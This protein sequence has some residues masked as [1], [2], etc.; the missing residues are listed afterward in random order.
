MRTPIQIKTFFPA[1]I[2]I[3]TILL[4]DISAR[5]QIVQT[6]SQSGANTLGWNAAIWGSPGAAPTSGN[7]YLTPSGFFVRTPNT[8][9]PGAFP[10][11]SLTISNA[12][13]YL[14]HDNGVATVNVIL[15][16]PTSQTGGDIIDYHGGPG[17][18]NV[19]LAG[20]LQVN[21]NSEIESDQT[22]SANE[23]IW[24]ECPLSGNGSL[25]VNM[26]DS[27]HGVLLFG[28]NSAYSGNWTNITGII[29]VMSGSSNALGSGSVTLNFS[30]ST[31]LIFNSTNNMAISNSIGGLGNVIQM[32][33]NTV[34]L[35]GTNTFA[36]F[37][38]ITNGGTLQ[39]GA[40]ATLTNSSLISLSGGTL[41]ASLIGGLTLGA[42]QSMNCNGALIGDLTVPGT[43]TLTFNFTAT[44]N[45]VLN[46][47]G[48]LTLNG[49]PTVAITASGFITPRTYRLINYNGTIQGGGSFNL[50]PPGGSTEVFQLD[51][52]TP[53]QVN[54]IVS[55]AVYNLTWVGDGVNNNW[56]L[57]ST[58]WFGATNVYADGDN[59]TFDDSGSA[60]PAIN[61][62]QTIHPGSVTINNDTNYYTFSG[63]GIVMTGSFAKT[64]TNEAD[65][66]SAANNIT[67]PLT[68]ES[69]I[70]S[71]GNGGITT[72]LGTPVSITNNGILQVNL[73]SGGLPLN[74]PI[75]GSGSLNITGGGASVTIGATN[76]YTG[77]TTIGDGCQLNISTS[78]ALGNSASVATVLANGRLGVN[79]LV[80]IMSVPQPLV[81]SGTGISTAPGAIYVNTSGNNVTWAG[82]VTVAA[83]AQF[84]TVNVSVH[85][86]FS[87]TVLGTNVALECTSGNTAGDSSTVMTFENTVS[88]GSSGSLTADGLAV[89]V[90]AGGTNVWGGGTTINNSGTLLV[91]GTLNGGPLADNNP[92]TLGG[93]GVILDPVTVDGTLAPGNLAI[94]TLTVSNTVTFNSD[95][96]AEFEINRTNAQ[97]ASL[98][99]AATVNCAGT[100]TVNN[101]G[102]TNLQAG[103]SFTLFSGAL[104]GSFSTT[105]LPALP[106]TN[107]FWDTSLLGSQGII[108]VNSSAVPQPTITSISVSGTTLTITATN[109]VVGGQ[110]V[111]L[112]STNLLLPVS[113]WTPIL[114][115]NFDNSGD[116]NLSTNVVNPGVPQEFY[117]LSP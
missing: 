14:K 102:P 101:I 8:T 62:V 10:G 32:N 25:N 71:F 92:A 113:Q 97:K 94:G 69:G 4:V 39:I 82:P 112:G 48:A 26:L 93:S 100:L 59:V 96:T 91:N 1:A 105:N 22:G 46:V 79:S 103:D 81:V 88:L 11:S 78:S 67:G 87:N 115:N 5:A 12:T 3:G 36:G 24:L 42:T 9:T 51:T 52:S 74:S 30:T 116:L 84:R 95:G 72:S 85:D 86:N 75:S 28:T 21:A 99:S 50:A 27:S 64:G 19:P 55:G 109:G 98:L 76:S 43:N 7:S 111:L 31:F 2:V 16:G 63:S 89:V 49:N 20:S 44:T 6:T 58:N 114:T 41:D 110:F 60:S 56:D 83:N 23:N 53:G 15:T 18:T 61:V 117:I 90:L 37:T 65:L 68:I 29:E 57:T 40:D 77:T 73:L 35:D 38:E 13:L 33:Q 47:N 108:K 45:A 34:T 104:S 17:G 80:G 106:S 107:L 54:L 70:L 66:T